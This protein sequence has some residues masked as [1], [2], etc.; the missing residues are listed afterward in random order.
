MALL[1]NSAL[2]RCRHVALTSLILICASA[3][4][5]H[6]FAAF[7]SPRLD[8]TTSWIGNSGPGEKEWIQQDIRALAVTADG[9]VFSNVEWEEGGGNVGEYRDGR[10]VRYARHTHGWGNLGGEAIA[11]NS[12]YLFI[13]MQVHNEGGGLKD[14]ATWPTNGLKWYGI[15][16]RLRTDI[17]R[18]APF[19]GG[20]G[21]KGDTLKESFLVVAEAPDNSKTPLP[22]L[23]AT[24]ERIYVADPYA[25]EVKCYDAETM[26]LLARWKVDAVGPIALNPAGEIWVLHKQQRN[27][28]SRFLRM[29]AADGKTLPAL[30][31]PEGV[32]AS[33]FCFAPAGRVLVFDDTAAQQIRIYVA[34][35][36][37][38]KEN[39]TFGQR[40]G[41]YSG[42]PGTPGDGKFNHLTAIGCDAKGN[43]Y[44]AHDGQSGGGGTVLES[45][46]AQ[47]KLNWRLHGL[48]F[49]DMADVD[50]GS[51]TDVFTKEE[52]FHMDYSQ[53]AGREWS[54]AGYTLQRFRYPDD[55]R[56]HI[57]SAGAWVRR[58]AGKR[59]LF[60]N[61][62]N[63][64][65]LQVYRFAAA[66]PGE[67][68]IPC[69]LFTGHHITGKD[70]WPPHQPPAGAW[71][72]HDANGNGAFDVNEFAG[73]PN[74]A[75]PY[76]GWWVDSAG[77]IWVA[78]ET[79][80]L[81]AF[82]VQGPDDDSGVPRW[83]AANLRVFDPP[84]EFQ[85]VKRVRYD[86]VTDTLF[87][88]G[89]TAEHQ[90]QHW[91]PM[92][93]VI[94]RYDGW[95][96]GSGVLRW[97]MVAP[98]AQGAQGHGSCEPMGFDVAGDYLF[99]PYTGASKPDGVKTGRVEVF[100]ISDAKSVGHF[101]PSPEV[102][103]I[104]L[105]DIRECLRAHRR[106]NGEYLIFL[107][108]D[109]KAKVVMYRWKP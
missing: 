72:W 33:A 62:M 88:G 13:G 40:G 6:S 55:P 2:C 75:P 44:A 105:Q 9:T 82:P 91:K 65:H 47:G 42:T 101:E 103:E 60:V 54:Y 63:G 1:M 86:P 79:R 21:G 22:G 10:L 106:A 49:V 66:E 15:S 38:L 46:S 74:D 83:P 41:I 24:E 58:I 68:A 67:I 109:Y 12:K 11:A 20:K 18:P 56:L 29:T 31:V 92:G 61:D 23:C 95:L 108:D 90:N 48:T 26:G 14:P 96:N 34:S 36:G 102:G 107:E 87:L 28:T 84:A 5:R 25:T 57:W 76:Q 35:G 59:F 4:P 52:H 30:A 85:K 17:T 39:G 104:G 94:A 51:D 81:R 89:T 3:L 78:T 93:P 27:G 97:K 98:Y 64:E 32:D 80:G 19:L 8:A 69:A 73:D 71:S 99:V 7:S 45:Y 16:R 53:P 50:P 100:R 43:V 70:G 77:T 37:A